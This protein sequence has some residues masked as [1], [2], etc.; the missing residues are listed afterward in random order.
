MKFLYNTLLHEAV[1]MVTG[2]GGSGCWRICAAADQV[3][4]QLHMMVSTRAYSAEYTVPSLSLPSTFWVT[5][6]RRGSAESFP[7][8][9]IVS[10]CAN[11]RCITVATRLHGNG[12][13]GPTRS[14]VAVIWN[15]YS[16]S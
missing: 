12:Y 1:D 14:S 3:V 6:I 7:W 11:A 9:R 15:L 2:D 16:R 4:L 10:S 8:R 13:D 5:F